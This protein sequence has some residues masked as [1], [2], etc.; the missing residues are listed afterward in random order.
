[1]PLSSATPHRARVRSFSSRPCFD[2]SPRNA[3]DLARR[4]YRFD[5]TAQRERE[6]NEKLTQ[7]ETL[8][9]VCS[10]KIWRARCNALCHQLLLLIRKRR[11]ADE[12]GRGGGG[13]SRKPVACRT[14]ALNKCNKKEDRGS[15]TVSFCDLCFFT[16]F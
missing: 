16:V 5:S 3:V 14:L 15:K 9:R 7:K 4:R 11:H 12:R 6:R 10:A 1:M 13:R 2:C 8:H